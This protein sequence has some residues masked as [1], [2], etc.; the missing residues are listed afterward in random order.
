M[1][2]EIENTEFEPLPINSSDEFVEE[3]VAQ[4]ITKNANADISNDDNLSKTEDKE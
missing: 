3:S 4:E 1:L 2:D